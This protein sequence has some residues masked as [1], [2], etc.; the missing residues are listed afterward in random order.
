[1]FESL[2]SDLVIRVDGWLPQ[3]VLLK[4]EGL[5]VTGSI[6]LVPA[7][8]MIADAER[9]GRLRPGG[10]IVESSSGNL[11]CALA[12]LAAAK[13]FR[14]VCV[15][16]PNALPRSVQMMRALGA[17][18]ILVTERDSSGG[19]LGSRI[20]RVKQEVAS[21]PNAIWLNQYANP[22]NAEAHRHQT[23]P[24][25]AAAIGYPDYLFLGVGTGGTLMGCLH[26]FAE[27]SPTT[28]I[29]A[30]DAVGSVTFGTPAGPRYIP[31]LGT[32]RRPELIQK[33]LVS[34]VVHV[35]EAETIAACRWLAR[36][37]GVLLGGSTG[38]VLA[39]MRR[40]AERL[41]SA[42]RVAAISPDMGERYL[43]TIYDD[44]WVIK[45]YGAD[46]L[47]AIECSPPHLPRTQPLGVIHHGK[48]SHEQL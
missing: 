5:N 34:D 45:T 9:A 14:F 42:C 8:A 35:P 33:D 21:R 30:V 38:T 29:I 48:R 40:Y 3:G 43:D 47:E 1:M 15:I 25:L 26:H 4:L 13:G 23:A 27:V 2:H 7:M 22:A 32:S 44:D 28:R 37:H 12:A 46:A 16:D 6:K 11:G 19:F 24:G 36:T 31:G 17:E 20:E 18:I 10:T 41:P 39:G